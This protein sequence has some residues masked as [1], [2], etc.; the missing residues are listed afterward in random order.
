VHWQSKD[1][2]NTSVGCTYHCL[3]LQAATRS[4]KIGS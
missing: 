4:N 3:G 2:R 1:Q